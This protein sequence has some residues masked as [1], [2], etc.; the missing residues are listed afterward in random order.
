MNDSEIDAELEAQDEIAKEQHEMRN[1]EN[2]MVYSLPPNK[3]CET[4]AAC[5]LV[6]RSYFQEFDDITADDYAHAHTTVIAKSAASS[7]LEY[8]HRALAML[9]KHW[10]YEIFRPGQFELI[11]SVARLRRDAYVLMATGAGTIYASSCI[12]LCSRTFIQDC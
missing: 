5:N 2:R 12:V 9:K 7:S 4:V 10:G 1:L 6:K 11:D 3:R 8:H